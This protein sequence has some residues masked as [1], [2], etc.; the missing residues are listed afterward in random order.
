MQSTYRLIIL[1]GLAISASL[2]QGQD[3][4]KQISLTSKATSAPRL[5]EELSKASGLRFTSGTQTQHDVL[6]VRL[7]DVT[8]QQAMDQIAS[9]LDGEWRA[10]DGGYLLTR[11]GAAELKQQRDEAARRGK[12]LEAAIKKMLAEVEQKP[13]L[14]EEDIQKMASENRQ[15]VEQLTQ[16]LREGG[17][18]QGALVRGARAFSANNR[19]SPGSRAVTKLLGAMNVNELAMLGPGSRTVFATRPTQVQKNLPNNTSQVIDQFLEEQRLMEKT[20]PLSGPG[21]RG[22]VAILGGPAQAQRAQTGK[23]GKVLLIVTRFGMSDGL[24]CQLSV[25]D[26]QSGE[27]FATGMAMISVTEEQPVPVTKAA[28]EQAIPISATTREFAAMVTAA[29]GGARAVVGTF[30]ALD[31]SAPAVQITPSRASKPTELTPEWKDRIL[32]PDSFEPLS[33]APSEIL[34]GLAE[35]RNLNL[36]AA[37][38]DE[39]LVP[40]LRRIQQGALFGSEALAL[41]SSWGLDAALSEGWLIVKPTQPATAVKERI[42]RK[43]LATMLKTLNTSG[44]LS[45]D[46]LATYAISTDA[47][48]V[49]ASLDYTYLKLLDPVTAERKLVETFQGNGEMLKFYGYLPQG[50]RQ[51]LLS[52]QQ[53]SIA[54]FNQKQRELTHSMVYNSMDGPRIELGPGAGR[55]GP[56]GPGGPMMMMGRGNLASERTEAL[57]T[58]IPSNGILTLRANREEAVLATDAEG[59]GAQFLNADALGRYRALAA[60]VQGGPFGANLEKFQLGEQTSL[61]FRFDFTRTAS[62]NRRLTDDKVDKK[63]PPV[64]FEQLPRDFRRRAEQASQR[65]QRGTGRE[66]L[67]INDGA[68]PPP[69]R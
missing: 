64:G 34:M 33:T 13:K 19:L 12:R 57:P 9:V 36:V 66:P 50:N 6:C 16:A 17:G 11:T 21:G 3:L 43:A 53:L 69:S 67:P 38:P 23:P 25:A 30:L 65:M 42:N 35:Q 41:A 44:R 39:S 60:N 48:N 54:S 62:L 28:N 47:Y 27:F 49:L 22:E 31:D 7:K 29:Q 51:T 10:S 56:G 1:A 58:G 59:G 37:L 14:T 40:T 26:A 4:S 18:G 61:N 45:L 52:G 63:L 5:L 32:Q 2:C 24:Q 15:Q 8:I 20:A 46:D 68:T 55:P